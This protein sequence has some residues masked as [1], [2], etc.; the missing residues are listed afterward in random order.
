RPSHEWTRSATEICRPRL[1]IVEA[2]FLP[3]RFDPRCVFGVRLDRRREA[4]VVPARL[5]WM[6]PRARGV[7]QHAV[8]QAGAELLD[9]T[10]FERRRRI[11]RRAE[12]AGKNHDAAFAG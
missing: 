3:A 11:D 2:V 12:D 9:V 10:V 7:D 8:P 6:L 4:F 1:Q 5:A